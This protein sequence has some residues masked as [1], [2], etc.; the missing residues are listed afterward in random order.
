MGKS[1]IIS[2][3]FQQLGMVHRVTQQETLVHLRLA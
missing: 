2:A 1:K 3:L